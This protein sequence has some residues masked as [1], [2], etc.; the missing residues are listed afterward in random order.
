[1]NENDLRVVKTKQSIYN[2]LIECMNKYPAKKITVDKIT[3][4][5]KINRSTFYKYYLDKFDL[6]DT[7]IEEVLSN[8]TENI[9]SD[10]V[11][12]SNIDIS[13]DIYH[14]HFTHILNLFQDNSIT[15][16]TL[17]DA[18]IERDIYTE[19]LYILQQNMLNIIY[20]D[21]I[22]QESKKDY[23]ILY[24]YLFASNCMTTIKWWF[25]ICPDMSVKDVGLLMKSNMENG[26]FQTYRTIIEQGQ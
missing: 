26:F 7:F 3:E 11:R 23:V 24:S 12:A 13:D 19:M 1:M 2:A 17:W 6:I 10:F 9:N 14:D 25:E 18:D 21:M 16:K 4:H 15:Y 22:F 8:F 20:T 5:A